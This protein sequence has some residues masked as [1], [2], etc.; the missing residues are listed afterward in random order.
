MLL[1]YD[2][3]H[4]YK[5]IYIYSPFRHEQQILQQTKESNEK[6]KAQIIEA[7]EERDGLLKEIEKKE[8]N[9]C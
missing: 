9:S 4:K 7:E 5:T 8:E 2:M 1:L 3:Q 6:I